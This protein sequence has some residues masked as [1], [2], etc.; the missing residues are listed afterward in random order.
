MK[1]II[2]I[3]KGVPPVYIGESIERFLDVYPYS[4]FEGAD[5]EDTHGYG[6]FNESIEVYAYKESKIIN[7]IACREN[8][9]LDNI[10]LIGL[11]IEKFLVHFKIDKSQYQVEKV[12][13]MPDDEEQDV[14]D[15][16]KLD[17]QIWVDNSYKIVTVFINGNYDLDLN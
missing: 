12:Y 14:Y 16:D 15:I 8:C 1:F 17:L 9:Y 7:F 10:N 2:E 4:F 5:F 13:L 3:N 6:F 11:N